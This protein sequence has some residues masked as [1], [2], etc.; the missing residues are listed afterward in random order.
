MK[1]D[2]EIDDLPARKTGTSR[3]PGTD[4]AGGGGMMPLWV[5]SEWVGLGIP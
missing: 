4:G 5:L 1:H 2:F 3:L